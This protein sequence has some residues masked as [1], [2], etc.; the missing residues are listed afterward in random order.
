MVRYTFNVELC[1]NLCV[2]SR[3]VLL[4]KRKL[5]VYMTNRI[6]EEVIERVR[7]SNDIVE[8]VGEFVQLKKRGK[9]YF[10]L[11]PFHE[12]NTPSFSVAEDK[13]IYHCFGCKKGGNVLSFIMEIE[14]LSFYESLVFLAERSE[15]ELPNIQEKSSTLENK[16]NAQLLAAYDWLAKLYHHVLRYSKDGD[17]GLAYLKSRGISEESIDAFQLG[18]APNKTNFTATFLEKKGFHRQLLVTSG[19]LSEREGND[20]A[21]PRSEE[22]TSELQSRFDLVC[23][24]LLETTKT[25]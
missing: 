12:E 18:Y 16:E 21:D 6:P 4:R 19:I 2:V 24:L 5:V 9:N 10:G 1:R 13:Q 22:H 20:V 3:R 7:Q 14:G 17:E 23:R 15:I 8:V 25:Y 11:C